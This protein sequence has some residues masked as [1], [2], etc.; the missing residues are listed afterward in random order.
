MYAQVI[1]GLAAKLLPSQ[2]IIIDENKYPYSITRKWSAGELGSVGIYPIAEGDISTGKQS[3]GSSLEFANGVVTRVHQVENLPLGT[4]ISTK[5]RD[6]SVKYNGVLQGGYVHDF[7]SEYGIQ[8]MQT[9]NL[10]DTANLNAATTL[11]Q[12]L[13]ASGQG[14]VENLAYLRTAENNTIMLTP[15]EL[16]VI[17]AA[18]AVWVGSVYVANWQFKDAIAAA[19]TKTKLNAIDLGTG[20]PS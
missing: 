12:T 17:T 9:R 10:E 16:I 13:V 14:D 15:N 2:N 18:L 1:N 7:G 20:W 5:S 19:D 11:S 6:L 4:L 3:K 8:H